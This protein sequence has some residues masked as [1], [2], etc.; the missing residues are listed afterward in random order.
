MAFDY[1]VNLDLAGRRCVVFGSGPLAVDRVQGLLASAA[2]VEVVTPEP[3]DELVALGPPVTRSIGVPDD[4]D[5][6]FLAIATREDGAPIGELW[7]AAIERGVLFA[8]LD[9]VA[10]CHFGAASIVRRGDLRVTI[11]TAGKAPALSKRL[12]QRLDEEIDEAHG[13][14]VEVLHRARERLLPREVPFATWAGAWGVALEDLDSLLE[15][16]RAGRGD[17]AVERVVASVRGAL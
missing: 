6:A 2:E 14:L 17:Q 9:D 12:R 5:G 11:S 4:L 7:E 16:V 15:L 10:H 1:P 13:E 3:S 8:A